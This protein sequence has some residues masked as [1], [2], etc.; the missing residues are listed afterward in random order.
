MLKEEASEASPNEACAILFGELSEREA[1]IKRIVLA[2]NRLKSSVRFEIDPETFFKAYTQAE[3][4]GFDLI[5]FFHSHPAPA[6]PSSI[7]L[8]YMELWSDTIWLILSLIDD[9][10]AAYQIDKGEVI[11]IKIV[12]SYKDTPL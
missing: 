9:R 8:E 3:K 12:F 4:D 11:E 1:Q 7:D 6:K 2:L 10:L 5:G